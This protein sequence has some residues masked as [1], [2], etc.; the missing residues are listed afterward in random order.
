MPDYR[1]RGFDWRTAVLIAAGA[2]VFGGSG[3][4]LAGSA[5]FRFLLAVRAAL[6]ILLATDLDQKLLPDW[7]TL[8]LIV[9]TGAWS[10]ARL[11]AAAR[12]QELGLVSG[13]AAGIIAPVFL[14]V[15]RSNP[16]RR[17]RRR[18]PQAR[19]ERRAADRDLAADH[20]AAHR[21]HR[22]LGRP[23]RVD[24]REAHRA[25]AS[26]V[27]FGP[28]LI[29]GGVRGRTCGD[30]LRSPSTPSGPSTGCEGRSRAVNRSVAKFFC[31]WPLCCWPTLPYEPGRSAANGTAIHLAHHAAG[32]PSR[33]AAPASR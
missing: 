10:G 27:P 1:S 8:P 11:V 24:R 9:I 15:S 22:L 28:V 19:G 26:A 14:F 20:R 21:E 17:P 6:M 30:R 4:S 2:V 5:R 32:L 31:Q 33:T 16:A 18:R 7:L 13:I 25:C 12:G 29:A 23:A 3:R